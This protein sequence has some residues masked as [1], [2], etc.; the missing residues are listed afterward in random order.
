ML[1][2]LLATP[3]RLAFGAGVVAVSV[4][5]VAGLASTA[6]FTNTQDGPTSAFP[7]GSVALNSADLS[8]G[9][10]SVAIT[11]IKPGTTTARTITVTNDGSASADYTFAES[12]VSGDNALGDAL[13]ATVTTQA[14]SDQTGATTLVSATSLRGLALTA[15]QTLAAAASDEICV[16]ITLPNGG[17]PTSNTSG[18][19]ALQDLAYSSKFVFT[20]S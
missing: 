1:G 3:A 5:G 4:A 9:T 12:K 17:T 11:D 13:Q 19:N 16:T 8:S 15:G 10:W 20:A 7:T 14:C 2:S 18:D 6:L